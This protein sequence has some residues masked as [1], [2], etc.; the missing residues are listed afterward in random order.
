MQAQQALKENCFIPS[1][2]FSYEKE[3]HWGLF[4][5]EEAKKFAGMMRAYANWD[6]KV[7]ILERE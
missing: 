6:V 4:S 3:P 7:I 5:E 1:L 2:V